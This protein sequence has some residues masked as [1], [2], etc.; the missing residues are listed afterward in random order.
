MFVSFNRASEQARR[1]TPREASK[2]ADAIEMQHASTSGRKWRRGKA[3]LVALSLFQYYYDCVPRWHEPV[4][5]LQ[6]ILIFSSLSFTCTNS[7]TEAVIRKQGFKFVVARALEPERL[8]RGAVPPSPPVRRSVSA[9][10]DRP[11]PSSG[12]MHRFV[13]CCGMVIAHDCITTVRCDVCVCECASGNLQATFTESSTN[14]RIGPA[15]LVLFLSPSVPRLAACVRVQRNIAS[16]YY[17][18]PLGRLKEVG[19]VCVCV[20]MSLASSRLLRISAAGV[21]T[22]VRCAEKY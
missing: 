14:A 3:R 5:P 20:W 17:K 6:P 8:R 9:Y 2:Y 1:A 22:R 12:P 7:D 4:R 10:G 16:Y 21:P 18:H 15:G 11:L 13:R 19:G